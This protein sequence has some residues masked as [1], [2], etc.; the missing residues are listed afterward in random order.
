MPSPCFLRKWIMKKLFTAIRKSDLESVREILK[1]DPSLIACTAKAPPKKDDG[2]SPLQIALKTD[3]ADIANYLL[4]MGA[5][6]NFIE[7]DDCI[8][9]WRAP[10]LH[11]AI[12]A[13]VM[14]SR[15]ND[16]TDGKLTVFSTA[17]RADESFAILVRMIEMGADVN[18]VDSV[19]NSCLW[20]AAIQ[21][22]QI[23]PSYDRNTKEVF[24]DR[25][26]TYELAADLSRIFL[27]LIQ[28]GADVEFNHPHL[29][30]S[31]RDY[32]VSNP[33]LRSLTAYRQETT[34]K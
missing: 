11:D 18:A 15:W 19:G 24:Q 4:D 31:F 16:Y 2:Q 29:G 1:K 20:R 13:A 26:L 21:A 28:H 12:N 6:V 34:P 22:G 10:V 14:T 30:I 3:N 8:N 27:L 5:D 25:L 33:L 9:N 32:F 17:K 23:L 7:S